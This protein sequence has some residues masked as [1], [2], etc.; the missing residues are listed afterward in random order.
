MIAFLNL[1]YE[2]LHY[3]YSDLQASIFL[4]I[5]VLSLT[6]LSI[7]FSKSQRNALF[8]ALLLCFWHASETCSIGF[9]PTLRILVFA[10]VMVLLS[11]LPY[12]FPRC[13]SFFK[14]LFYAF[15]ICVILYSA[16]L[17]SI[18]TL[19]GNLISI[20][21]IYDFF[22]NKHEPI[23]H[24]TGVLWIVYATF[25]IV[26]CYFLTEFRPSINVNSSNVN[27]KSTS[28]STLSKVRLI[29]LSAVGVFLSIIFFTST[30]FLFLINRW[31]APY[32]FTE[33]Y[34][35]L[36]QY[37]LVDEKMSDYAHVDGKSKSI[38]DSNKDHNSLA[39][40]VVACEG[41]CSDRM[42]VYGYFRN[43]TP[44]LN[45]MSD[46]GLILFKENYSSSPFT[47]YSMPF[48]YGDA[49][50]S[51]KIESNGCSV[52]S[53]RLN[54][55]LPA[56]H[57]PY[58]NRS[59]HDTDFS[60]LARDCINNNQ[61]HNV[62]LMLALPY[63]CN[64]AYS[65][66]FLPKDLS[67]WGLKPNKDPNFEVVLD[68]DFPNG[69]SMPN[70]K[71]G[72]WGKNLNN[73]W[74]NIQSLDN[75]ILAFDRILSEFFAEIRASS[76]P[77]V[78]LFTSSNG[79]W[80]DLQQQTYFGKSNIRD[81]ILHTPLGILFNT[82]FAKKYHAHLEMLRTKCEAPCENAFETILEWL[83]S[84]KIATP[85]N[86]LTLKNKSICT[87]AEKCKAR[88]D[89]MRNKSS[90]NMTFL[91]HSANTL[92]DIEIAKKYGLDGVEIDVIYNGDDLIVGHD[93]SSLSELSLDN[94]IERT[95]FAKKIC[96][97]MKNFNSENSEKIFAILNQLD[98]K[99]C[100]KKR[101]LI[102]TVFIGEWT[103]QYIDQGWNILYHI[104]NAIKKDSKTDSQSACTNLE[105]LASGEFITGFSLELTSF[106]ELIPFCRKAF[107]KKYISVWNFESPAL[108][109]KGDPYIYT[110]NIDSQIW[111]MQNFQTLIFSVKRD[112][113]YDF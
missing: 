52:E 93:K 85:P 88:I 112:T 24:F 5:A 47:S 48:L 94:F 27:K 45:K 30:A 72:Y 17:F 13:F 98:Q 104:P 49:R 44:F 64:L 78:V 101:V 102:E 67:K 40:F 50:L 11:V 22:I 65:S 79:I 53:L 99:F 38:V 28:N 39:I 107:S 103:R 100:I 10:T 60:R 4:V 96:L 75:G 26:L 35:V 42:S 89:L 81:E 86:V 56:I 59:V 23:L 20:D 74:V 76:R 46:D 61:N 70:L 12:I 73:G 19:V 82:A 16:I 37:D 7:F 110:R 21:F 58:I 57:G 66:P 36:S 55:P 84:S 41:I 25:P 68:S 14:H 109:L 95:V 54:K 43:T 51:K 18:R 77:A 8:C 2:F 1:I 3:P 9:P 6:S 91:M 108:Y 105:R 87:I 32:I 111:E 15:T 90:H 80:V 33:A 113:S 83:A 62:C 69:F 63:V 71:P 34:R 92:R 31:S 97:N 29:I 106:N